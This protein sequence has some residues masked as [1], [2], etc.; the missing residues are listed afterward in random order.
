MFDAATDRPVTRF[1]YAVEVIG[2][3][4]V[5]GTYS[6]NPRTGAPAPIDMPFNLRIEAQGYE[7]FRLRQ[8]LMRSGEP[9]RTHTIRLRHAGDPDK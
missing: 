2:T 7:T 3:A 9:R 5:R 6:G 8:V 1:D 4:P